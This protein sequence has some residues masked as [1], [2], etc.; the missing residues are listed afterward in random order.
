M[1]KVQESL[2]SLSAGRKSFALKR[3]EVLVICLVTLVECRPSNS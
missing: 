3:I 1:R 2:L